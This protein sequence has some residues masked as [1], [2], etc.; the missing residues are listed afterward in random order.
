MPVAPN[1]PDLTNDSGVILT[2]G[3][4]T[5]QDRAAIVLPLSTNDSSLDARG[6]CTNAALA[7]E[8]ECIPLLVAGLGASAYITFLQ[9]VGMVDGFIP[10]RTDYGPLDHPGTR[11]GPGECSQIAALCI[12]YALPSD[13]PANGRMRVAKNFIPGLSDTDVQ[14]DYIAAA[15][16][17][18]LDT[19]LEKICNGF[20]DTST[21]SSTWYRVLA[22]PTSRA[23]GQVVTRVG[24]AMTRL[25]VGTQRRRL[26][27]RA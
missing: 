20:A 12:Y 1:Q 26:I 27:P 4:R 18:A 6:L 10:A 9:A 19:F 8:S 22:T 2:V 16:Q 15:V 5:P 21:P 25:Y 7:F 11:T 14:G 24:L 3:I 17:T 13:L 23:A